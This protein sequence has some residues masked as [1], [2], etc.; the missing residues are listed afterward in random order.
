M[1]RSYAHLDTLR[2]LHDFRPFVYLSHDIR[3]VSSEEIMDIFESC[4]EFI[5]DAISES[6]NNINNKILVHCAAGVSRSPTI[7]ISYL[8]RHHQY[9]LDGAYAYIVHRRPMIKPNVGFLKQLVKYHYGIGCGPAG[10]KKMRAHLAGRVVYELTK[11]FGWD[12]GVSLVKSVEEVRV[13]VAEWMEMDKTLALEVVLR[14]LLGMKAGL[15]CLETVIV[16][17][18]EVIEGTDENKELVMDILGRL[19]REERGM[20][21]GK[22]PGSQFVT[23]WKTLVKELGIDAREVLH[24][25]A[26]HSC[27]FN[28]ALLK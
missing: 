26:G 17:L 22:A 27:L 1:N 4:H 5:S 15:E 23:V 14:C 13:V 10:C 18:N 20:T 6:N 7:T 11:R 2:H 12:V 19:V 24:E 21:L 28:D 3:D 9:T 25:K 16:V 8:M